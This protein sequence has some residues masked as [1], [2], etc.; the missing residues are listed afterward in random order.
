MKLSFKMRLL[1]PIIISLSPILIGC[2]SLAE[3]YPNYTR[4]QTYQPTDPLL[5]CNELQT[6]LSSIDLAISNMDAQINNINEISETRTVLDEFNSA[7][8][9]SSGTTYTP[10]S[11]SLISM[12]NEDVNDINKVSDSYQK[13]RDV[14]MDQFYAKSCYI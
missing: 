5:T 6:E 9:F 1:L 4:I 8:A 14:L 10:T 7:L 2:S 12:N 3:S 13:R 11:S